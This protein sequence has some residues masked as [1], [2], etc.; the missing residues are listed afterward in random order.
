[1]NRTRLI[2]TLVLLS[3]AVAIACGCGNGTPVGQAPA[4]RT[5]RQAPAASASSAVSKSSAVENDAV[6]FRDDDFVESEL[7]RDPF[8]S[9]SKAFSSENTAIVQAQR[10]VLLERYSIDELKLVAIV[11]A[12]SESRAMFEDPIGT[13]WIVR[14]GQF[15]GKAEIVRS[16]VQ[17]GATYE[18]NWR[19]DRIRDGDVVL[20]CD[21]PSRTDVAPA[22]RVIA[23][24]Q[25]ETAGIG[26]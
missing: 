12:G 11:V 25:D 14:R 13:G 20:V 7:S 17:G 23:L 6:V 5:P 16:Q 22:V 26:R 2:K 3:A 18:R 8:R 15:I 9:F 4:K 1:M 10:E 19:V 21:D 24:R